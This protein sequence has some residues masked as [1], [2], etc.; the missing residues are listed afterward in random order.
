MQMVKPHEDVNATLFE[1]SVLLYEA[2]NEGQE[3]AGNSTDK[4]CIV[5]KKNQEELTFANPLVHFCPMNK[6]F[7]YCKPCLDEFVENN[8][9]MAF[10]SNGVIE[11]FIDGLSVPG[12]GIEF[13]P[14]YKLN[15]VPY[16]L[17]RLQYPQPPYYMILERVNYKRP[18]GHKEGYILRFGMDDQKSSTVTF[19]SHPNN[20]VYVAD[21]LCESHFSIK[22]SDGVFFIIDHKDSSG[23]YIAKPGAKFVMSDFF[24]KR[25]IMV[26]D[27]VI[28][29]K[30][31]EEKL[32][33]PPEAK[34][35]DVVLFP[36]ALPC[37]AY[38]DICR[39]TD[40]NHDLQDRQP[41]VNQESGL[42][43]KAIPPDFTDIDE[44]IGGD[45]QYPVRTIRHFSCHFKAGL[46]EKAVI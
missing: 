1:D 22:F 17:V 45:A 38:K 36:K 28:H 44:E 41:A 46:S 21:G 15:G 13:P 31:E 33:T 9:R 32:V 14:K 42:D 37:S 18:N 23:T 27:I 34:D 8:T 25:S 10:K 20:N 16:D 19:G 3:A 26:R 24:Y 39:E 43:W 7:A 12:T 40:W 2:G 6:A 11:Y 29:F 4:R 30:F 35:E 5:C